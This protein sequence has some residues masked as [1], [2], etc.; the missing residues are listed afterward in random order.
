MK[1]FVIIA[2]IL[3]GASTIAEA[4][5]PQRARPEETEYYSPVPP[6]VTPGTGFSDAPSDAI[7]L[8]DGRNLD[9]WINSKDSTAAKWTLGDNVMTVNKSIGD[10]QTRSSFTDYQMHIEYKIPANIT[11][12]G[13]ARGNSGIFLATLP[14]GSGYELQVLDNYKNT[15]YV[16]GQVGSMYKQAVP[17]A[18]ASKKPGEWQTY[19][20][21]WTSPKF[22]DHGI[23]KSMARV[24]VLH[25]GVLVQNNTSLLGD[26]PYIGQPSYRKHGAAPIKLQSHGDKSEPI[27]YRNI[28]LRPL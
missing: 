22:D 13:Q 23:L 28:W 24:T 16:N 3:T 6:V 20:I 26:T 17:L 4:Q 9:Q 8:F 18:N 19:D 14:W 10:I 25:N 5:A 15:T 27:S 12:S 21:V 2:A 1:K 7:I 11:G